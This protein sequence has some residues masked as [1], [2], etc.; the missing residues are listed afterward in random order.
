MHAAHK[1]SFGRRT[2]FRRIFA[3]DEYFTSRMGI[4]AAETE[5]I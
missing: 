4:I 3:G 2:R 1:P 5:V